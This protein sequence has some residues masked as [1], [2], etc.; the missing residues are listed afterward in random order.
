MRR[1]LL[2][3]LAALTGCTNPN[4]PRFESVL[5]ANDSATAALGQWCGARQIAQP[6]VIRALADRD[7]KLI[8]TP[9]V[10]AAL[11]VPNDAQV[12]YRHVRLACGDHVLSVAHNWYVPARLTS[13]MNRTL[14]TTDTPFGKV[15]TPLGFR[16]ERL[17]AQRGRAEECPKG[18]VLS[19]R[20]VLRLA[21]GSAISLVVECYTPANLRASG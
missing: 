6:P 13:D 19:H 12:A 5:A 20:A 15:V 16:R 9:A 7:A 11:G 3:A 2:A 14:E 4:L 10:L 17:S 18:T 21:N 1:V 8:P